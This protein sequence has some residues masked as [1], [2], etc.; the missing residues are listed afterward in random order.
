MKVGV[1]MLLQNEFGPEHDFQAIQNDLRLMSL[2]EPLGYDSIWTVEHHFTGYSLS[3]NALMALSYLAGQTKRVE[4]GTQVVV[5]PWHQPVR[6]AGEISFLDNMSGGRLI[7]GIGRGLARH[8]FEGFGI[9]HGES[10]ERFIESAELVL[11]ALETG[12]AK[13]DGKYYQQAEREIRPRPLRSFKGRTYAAAV[14]PESVKIMARL[15]VGILIIPQKPWDAVD[16]DLA[17]YDRVYREVNGCAPPPTVLGSQ[18]FCDESADRAAELAHK[19][20][21]D[22]FISVMRHYELLGDHLKGTQGYEYYA[23]NRERMVGRDTKKTADFYTGLQVWGTPEQCY[24]KIMATR[25]RINCDHFCGNFH[26]I[27]MPMHEGER[28]MRLFAE[29]VL[30]ELKKVPKLHDQPGSDEALHLSAVG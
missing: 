7:L 3:P 11:D 4:L 25:A 24:E 28:S 8:E 18:V 9:P 13:Y 20:I 21:G 22:Y 17:T 29:K 16:E 12:T 26:F 19:Y 5:L 10:R 30:P 15:G 27:D 2:A 6:A 14:S 23:A 1:Q